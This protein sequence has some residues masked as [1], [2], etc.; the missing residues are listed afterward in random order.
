MHLLVLWLVTCDHI[1]M[2]LY[3]T[4]GESSNPS[5]CLSPVGLANECS[6]SA[7]LLYHHGFQ[8]LQSL[9]RHEVEKAMEKLDLTWDRECA[10]DMFEHMI[11]RPF[12]LLRSKRRNP[13]CFFVCI[14]VIR[15]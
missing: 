11:V 4:A 15:H 1:A 12:Q 13:S 7:A 9:L 14:L 10:W 8:G 6:D 5:A 2:L 3:L